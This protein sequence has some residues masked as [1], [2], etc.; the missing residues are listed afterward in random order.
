MNTSM[1]K[2]ALLGAMAAIASLPAAAVETAC[3]ANGGTNCPAQIPDFP[4]AALTSTLTVPQLTC[5][6]GVLPS[7][8][9]VR[10][11]ITHNWTGD[12]NVSLTNPNS[13]TATIVTANPLT[14]DGNDLIATYTNT[15]LLGAGTGAWTLTV[16]DTAN[17][18][19]G[20]LND[21]GVDAVCR[22]PADVP[23]LSPAPM[24]GMALLLAV[25]GMFSLRRY[26]RR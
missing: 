13:T 3:V 16:L 4:Q 14:N 6:G 21:W 22:A 26:L 24:T 15:T 19:D 8:V 1:L 2:P 20:A 23:A 17:G 11:D 5:P 9:A 10:L 7:G 25:L 12:L 18:G